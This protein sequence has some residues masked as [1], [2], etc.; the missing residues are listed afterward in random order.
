[1]RLDQLGQACIVRLVNM[2]LHYKDG[3]K[4]MHYASIEELVSMHNR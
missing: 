4:I 2:R 1:M 3:H